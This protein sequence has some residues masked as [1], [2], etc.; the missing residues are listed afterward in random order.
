ME[1]P[2][3]TG[4]TKEAVWPAA[5]EAPALC[6]FL[7]GA[8]GAVFG[9]A[10]G[11]GADRWAG[12]SADCPAADCPAGFCA[13]CGAGADCAAAPFAPRVSFRPG[14]IREGSEPT[15]SRLSS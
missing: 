10:F 9:L 8:A 4:A 5:V 11:A 3:P 7:A 14:W 15:A 2:P 12:C 1:M 13:R 6:C